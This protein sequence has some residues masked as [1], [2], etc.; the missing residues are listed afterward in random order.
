VVARKVAQSLVVSS[1]LGNF[2]LGDPDTRQFLLASHVDAK[3][4]IYSLGSHRT[5]ITHLHMNTVHM[6]D[7]IQRIQWPSVPCLH[8]IDHGIRYRGDSSGRDFRAIHFFQVTLY[9]AHRHAT[10]IQRQ[11][12]DRLVIESAPAGLVLGD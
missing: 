2:G 8:F 5:G 6:D 9:L 4:E 12:Q 3:C 10:G 1:E 7:G 11:A